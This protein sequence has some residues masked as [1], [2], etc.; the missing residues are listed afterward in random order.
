PATRERWRVGAGAGRGR[1]FLDLGT[2]QVQGRPHTFEPPAPQRPATALFGGAIRLVGY[3]LDASEAHPGGTVRLSLHWQA[4]RTP[5]EG[6]AAFVHLVDATGHILAQDDG[7]P[8]GGTLP[9][10]S[11]LPGEFVSERHVLSLPEEAAPGT[12]R[13]LV[14]WYRPETGTRVP[15]EGAGTVEGQAWVLA[16][17]SLPGKRP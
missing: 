4:V 17:V 15:V 9:T 7:I 14:G 13:L 11:W 8:G 3:D 16:E 6:W 5:S 1:D 12:Y 2:V 10:T